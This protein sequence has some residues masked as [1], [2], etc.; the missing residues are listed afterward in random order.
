MALIQ[1]SDLDKTTLNNILDGNDLR[2]AFAPI[3]RRIESVK[4]EFDQMDYMAA[5]IMEKLQQQIYEFQKQRDQLAQELDHQ[6]YVLS[7]TPS[8]AKE[9]I[10]KVNSA[11]EKVEE[12]KTVPVN[13]EK[14]KALNNEIA[15]LERAINRVL[16][17]I[18]I[19]DEARRKCSDGRARLSSGKSMLDSAITSVGFCES[20]F[21]KTC[22]EV[23]DLANGAAKAI[24]SYLGVSIGTDPDLHISHI[25]RK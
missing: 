13:Q 18:S 22:A 11:G 17:Y 25:G 4:Q 6:R 2:D 24:A 5:Q 12:T 3:K 7:K 14:I 9:K 16:E 20:A 15:R 10:E 19:L 1:Y 21:R 23:V 8:T